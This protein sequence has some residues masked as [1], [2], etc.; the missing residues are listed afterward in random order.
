M[1][2][3]TR[4]TIKLPPIPP[5]IDNKEVRIY[6]EKVDIA[7][8]HFVKAVYD[9]LSNGRVQHRAY[10]TVPTTSDVEKGEVVF[11]SSGSTYRLYANIAGTMKYITM[12]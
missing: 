12:S 8:R 6:L 5:Q 3:K 4:P 9:D 2:I 1:A 10:T 7:I 11:Y